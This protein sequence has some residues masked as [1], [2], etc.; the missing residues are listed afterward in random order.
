MYHLDKLFLLQ[1]FMVN[2]LKFNMVLELFHLINSSKI[3][4]KSIKLNSF[5]YFNM[6]QVIIMFILLLPK[7]KNARDFIFYR[8]VD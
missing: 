3:L 5:I 6:F 1:I 7:Y 4:V 2:I 8:M